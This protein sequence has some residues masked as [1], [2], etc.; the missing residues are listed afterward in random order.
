[1]RDPKPTVRHLRYLGFQVLSDG[2]RLL[3]F[4]FENADTSVQLISVQASYVLFSGPDHIAI[5][6]CPGI[7]YETL[8]CRVDS[9]S[10]LVPA[11]IELTAADVAQHRK[12]PKTLR[13]IANP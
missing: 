2:T 8:K 1:M 12:H 3:E 10:E 13:R 4:S 5:Q 11:S 6:E 9:C 7:C